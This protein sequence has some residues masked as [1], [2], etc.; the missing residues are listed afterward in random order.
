[1]A[2]KNSVTTVYRREML[3]KITSGAIATIPKIAKMAF[4]DGGTD[5]SNKPIPP[6][7]TATTLKHE[8]TRYDIDSVSYPVSTTARYTATIPGDTLVN[9]NINEA[10]LVDAD[11]KICLI[12]T[13][14]KKG[15]DDGVI[16]TFTLD[17]EFNWRAE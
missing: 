6:L 11:G 1:M 2:S 14:T 8:L 7:E 4:G 13:M 12:Q 3:C 5:G 17:E 15:K 9:A 10:A 16:F